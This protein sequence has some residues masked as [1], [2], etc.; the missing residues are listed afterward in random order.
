[1]YT[2]KGIDPKSGLYCTHP[3]ILMGAVEKLFLLWRSAELTAY[4]LF[5]HSD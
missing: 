4:S 5:S 2:Q 1:M 3:K